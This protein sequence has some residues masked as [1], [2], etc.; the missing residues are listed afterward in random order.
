MVLMDCRRRL[1]NLLRQSFCMNGVGIGIFIKNLIE[2]DI[3]YGIWGKISKYVV[4][5]I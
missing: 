2:W 3:F 5:G 1:L 4:R